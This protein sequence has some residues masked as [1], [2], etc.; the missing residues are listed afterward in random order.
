MRRAAKQ[1]VIVL[2]ANAALRVRQGGL[3]IEH[4]E[5]LDRVKLRIDIDGSTA[6]GSQSGAKA[7][8]ARSCLT[9]AANFSAARHCDGARNAASLSSCPTGRAARSHSLKRR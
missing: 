7:S 4:G 8:L 2:G 6:P 3:E 9:G 1:S 5:S